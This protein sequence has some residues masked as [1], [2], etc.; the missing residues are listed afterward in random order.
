M[1]LRALGMVVGLLLTMV[2]F[3]LSTGCQRALATASPDIEV[4]KSQHM[5]TGDNLTVQVPDNVTFNF[6]GDVPRVIHGDLVIGVFTQ[7]HSAD[8]QHAMDAAIEAV[9]TVRE[10]FGVD[11][12]VQLI[13]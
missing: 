3:F 5:L 7:R 6:T 13:P 1:T 11:A 12:D 8:S 10:L 2:V 4:A 9:N